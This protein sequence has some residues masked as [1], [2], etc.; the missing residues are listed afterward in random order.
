MDS[1]STTYTSAPVNA[2]VGDNNSIQCQA[3][4]IAKETQEVAPVEEWGGYN[5][6][7][8]LCVIA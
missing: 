6:R 2:P 8:I 3:G 1:F 7:M 4:I 5:H